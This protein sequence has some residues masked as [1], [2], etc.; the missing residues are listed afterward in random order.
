MSL[1]AH[2]NTGVFQLFSTEKYEM[3]IIQTKINT[4]KTH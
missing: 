4:I 3:I 2:K 1:L